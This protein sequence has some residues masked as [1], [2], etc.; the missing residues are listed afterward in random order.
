MGMGC[1]W[2]GIRGIRDVERGDIVVGF[3]KLVCGR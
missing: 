1:L 2:L 3:V